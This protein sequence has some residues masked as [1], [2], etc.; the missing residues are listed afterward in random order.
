MDIQTKLGV[1]ED[2]WDTFTPTERYALLGGC[3]GVGGHFYEQSKKQ[4]AR[5]PI[6]I[7]AELV[8]LDWSG[9]LGRRLPEFEK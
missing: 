9:M 6:E 4:W 2:L 7:R 5:L 8:V 1:C 3:L